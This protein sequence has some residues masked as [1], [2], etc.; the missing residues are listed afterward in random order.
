M[1]MT[2]QE[3]NEAALVSQAKGLAKWLSID[4]TIKIFGYV[5]LEYHF[6]PQTNSSNLQ[7]S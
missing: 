4:L 6:P 7:N 2:R 5:L 3:R 1:K